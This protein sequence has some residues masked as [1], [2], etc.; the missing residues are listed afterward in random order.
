MTYQQ[1]TAVNGSATISYAYAGSGPAI[2]FMPSVGRSCRDFEELA[3]RLVEL[4]HTVILPEPRGMN[5]ST[6]PLDSLDLHEM[7]SDAAAAARV[8]ADR[9]VF[10]GHAF[11]SIVARTACADFPKLARGLVLI[12]AGAEHF[13]SHL[14][15]AIDALSNLEED[16]DV[17]LDALQKTFFAPGHDP[18]PWLEGWYVEAMAAQ[19]KARKRTDRDRWWGGGKAPILDL[20]A[21]QDPFRTEEYYGEIA[22]EFGERVVCRFVDG[23]SHALP[24]EKPEEVAAEISRFV[25]GLPA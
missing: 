5:G 25:A 14:S 12:A 8:V 19:R 17:R 13:P 6:G 3:L 16:R 18:S 15:T 2:C 24:H 20:I 22:D 1:G 11:G 7:A 9:V 23:A 21:L 4:G 10:A